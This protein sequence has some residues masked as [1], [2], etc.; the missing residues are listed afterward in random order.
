MNKESL[1]KKPRSYKW[2]MMAFGILLVCYAFYNFGKNDV[3]S[4]IF[5]LS[6]S[7]F[8][9]FYGKFENK[10]FPKSVIIILILIGLLAQIDFGESNSNE[11]S[12]SK[13]EKVASRWVKKRYL[14]DP[15][16]Y[17][18]IEYSELQ[19]TNTK[20]G[21]NYGLWHSFRAKN[22]L[23]KD[24]FKKVYVSIDSTGK[25]ISYVELE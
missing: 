8:V 3:T 7:G 14:D 24:V 15:V 22:K 12:Q 18:E 13:A 1:I 21:R 5:I 25:V 17:K 23:G 6:A 2:F 19:V 11:I 4:G 20:S 9:I 16:S 10:K